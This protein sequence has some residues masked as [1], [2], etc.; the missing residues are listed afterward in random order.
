MYNEPVKLPRG[1]HYGNN[2]FSVYSKKLKRI[3]NFFSNIEYYNFLSLEMNPDVENFCEQP[4]EIEIYVDGETKKAVLDMW[5]LYKDG[6]EEFQEVK[7]ES[8]LTGS[9]QKSLRS[10]EQIKRE[11]LWCKEHNYNFVV[12]TDTDICKGKYTV[13]NLNVMAARVRRYTPMDDFYDLYIQ[14]QLINYEKLSIGDMIHNNMLPK[15]N[16]LNQICYMYYK[17][18]ITFDISNRPLD[19]KTIIRLR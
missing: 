12:R 19:E 7:Y 2:Y 18:I 15:G 13:S 6:T 1:T 16:E 8:E 4:R 9:D 5:V 17:G 10:Q 14:K 11:M 3:A